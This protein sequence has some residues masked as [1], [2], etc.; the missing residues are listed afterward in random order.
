MVHGGRQV[1]RPDANDP[2]FQP[3]PTRVVG[4]LVSGMPRA[5][6][7]AQGIEV[8]LGA[9]MATGGEP[10]ATP[11]TPGVQN[12]GTYYRSIGDYPGGKGSGTMPQQPGGQGGT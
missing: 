3:T 5:G 9:D 7:P 4:D 10:D 2:V 12:P 8:D 1:P 11:E 6:Y